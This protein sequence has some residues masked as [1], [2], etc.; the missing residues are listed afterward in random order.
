M[1][2]RGRALKPEA[3]RKAAAYHIL[4]CLPRTTEGYQNLMTGRERLHLEG[5]YYQPRVDQG[6]L[7]RL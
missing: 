7:S 1:S 3:G 5:F 2:P 4:L 6:I